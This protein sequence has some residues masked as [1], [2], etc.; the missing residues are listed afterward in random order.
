MKN[1]IIFIKQL[2]KPLFSLV[3]LFISCFSLSSQILSMNQ[4]GFVGEWYNSSKY[5]TFDFENKKIIHQLKTFY[6][7]WRDKEVFTDLEDI[8]I[9][10][11]VYDN[12]LFLQY[13]ELESN[14]ENEPK[15]NLYLPTSNI[16]EISLDNS[17]IYNQIYGFLF[18]DEEN[19][20]K[21][22]YW[23][24]NLDLSQDILDTQLGI[25]NSSTVDVNSGSVLTNLPE[26][27]Y[28]NTKK[29]IQISDKIYTCVEGRGTKVRNVE[30]INM[31]NEYPNLKF[32]KND[33]ISYLVLD[34]AYMYRC[35][36]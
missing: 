23:L 9:K 11:L 6:G 24:V 2:V 7:L 4:E 27:K 36:D 22:R 13:W 1:I 21:I 19:V 29:Y 26:D 30:V 34:N 8:K 18:I 14:I 12:Q 15:F 32:I 17:I 25:I 16:D 5:I 31:K 28:L 33:D 35:I 3:L 20:I 10:P